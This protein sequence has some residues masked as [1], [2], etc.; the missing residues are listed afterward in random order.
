MNSTLFQN[1]SNSQ[2]FN[3]LN[4]IEKLTPTEKKD[5]YYCPVCEGKNFTIKEDTG[6]YQCWNG[7][8]VAD[9]RN[10]VAPLKEKSTRT[11]GRK[12]IPKACMFKPAPIPK[13]AKLLVSSQLGDFPKSKPLT[14]KPPKGAVGGVEQTIYHYSADQWVIRYQWA[15]ASKP[16]GYAKTFRQFHKNADG[17]IESNKGKR[18]WK[19]YRL[20]EVLAHILALG[21]EVPAVLWGE[22]E[23]CVEIAREEGVLSIT[24]QGSNWSVKAI[25]EGL[26]PI[27]SISPQC[28][29]VFIADGDETGKKKGE[30]FEKACAEVGLPCIVI[31]STSFEVEGD[32]EEI[33]QSMD[34]PDFIKRLEAEIH[35]AA[36]RLAGR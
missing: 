24:L 17:S 13:G 8:E 26:Q 31:P 16:K 33:L 1:Q 19:P 10:A 6:A 11:A 28:I 32:I 2:S 15:D 25:K 7:C 18:P 20:D 34:V 35:A 3:I 9:I 27:A 29:Q 36:S 4:H 21:V 5:R 12:P 30:K 22:G 14:S 23:K